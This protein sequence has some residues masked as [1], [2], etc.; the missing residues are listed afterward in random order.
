MIVTPALSVVRLRAA[1]KLTG[2]RASEYAEL[3]WTACVKA[4]CQ[5]KAS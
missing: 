3:S 1:D 4:T 5:S 2:Q